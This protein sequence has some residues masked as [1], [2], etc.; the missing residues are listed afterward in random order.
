MGWGANRGSQLTTHKTQAYNNNVR[1]GDWIIKFRARSLAVFLVRF[2]YRVYPCHASS[3]WGQP[4]DPEPLLPAPRKSNQV[5]WNLIIKLYYIWSL[6]KNKHFMGEFPHH[7]HLL[8]KRRQPQLFQ[9]SGSHQP[10]EPLEP[11]DEIVDRVSRMGPP[12]TRPLSSNLISRAEI[13]PRR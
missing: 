5:E 7:D 4:P 1:Q 2:P 9:C 6:C 8:H 11:C 3:T 12:A 10:Y 13:W